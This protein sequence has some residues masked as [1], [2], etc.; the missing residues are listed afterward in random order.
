MHCGRK[1]LPT[2]LCVEKRQQ[3][4]I[5][6]PQLAEL[7]LMLGTTPVSQ[8]CTLAGQVSG[9]DEKAET[10]SYSVQVIFLLL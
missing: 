7:G 8:P 3:H 9:T 6:G 4:G 5:A 10:A 1:L 2:C